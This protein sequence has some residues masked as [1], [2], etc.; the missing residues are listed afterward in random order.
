MEIVIIALAL[1]AIVVVGFFIWLVGQGADTSNQIDRI[2]AEDLDP[3][4][5]D[6]T[7]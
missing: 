3:S 4:A 6:K 5:E 7:Q 1:I 2:F